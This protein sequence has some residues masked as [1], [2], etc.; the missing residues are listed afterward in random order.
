MKTKPLLTAIGALMVVLMLSAS[1]H[2]LNLRFNV[3][4]TP[5]HPLCREAFVPWAK[6]VKEVTNGRV[7]VTMFYSNALFKPKDALD[8]ISSRIGDIGII[9]P[10]YTRD[11]LMMNSVMEQPMV[12]NE[13]ALVNSEVLWELF[14]SVP[15]M[16]DE[17]KDIKVLWAYMNPAFQ[18]HFTKKKVE[19]LND[20]QNTVISAGGTTQTQILRLLGASPEAMP[21]VDVFLAMQKGVVEGCFL[22]YAP[23][24]TQKIADL[25]K[26]HTNANLMAVS[27][28]ITINK[29]AWGKIS[30][31][32]QKAIEAISGLTVAQKCGRVFDK[33]QERDTAWMAEK[34]DN[35]YALSAEQQKLWA[36]KVNPVRE[37]W[38]QDA[39]AKGYA[40]PEKVL[41]KALQLMAEKSK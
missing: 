36:E 17:L 30:P 7:K 33:A 18:L 28:F 11:R 16:Q 34:G 12:A 22:P 32:D 14:Q 20:L 41:E 9:L 1:A 40:N 4:F 38:I 23:L 15:E 29:S 31:E 21:M 35:F 10:T 2:A 19:T 25:I 13:K 37:A 5:K 6:Q 24:R 39:K 26:F 3:M 8:A 27:F